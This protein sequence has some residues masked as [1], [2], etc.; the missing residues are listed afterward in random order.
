MKK[1]IGIVIAALI[2][3]GG[4]FTYKN[5]IAKEKNNITTEGNI[6]VNTAISEEKT[7]SESKETVH[8][9]IEQNEIKLEND[10]DEDETKN[11]INTLIEEDNSKETK[12][13]NNKVKK[14]LA[15]SGFMG[16]SLL[17]VTLYDNGEVYLIRY[18][19]EGYEDKNVEN[20]EI[21]ATNAS[22]IKSKGSGEDF[23]A[24]VIKGSSNFKIKNKNYS[25]I[26]FEN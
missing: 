21:L 17:R 6:N 9:N 3:C 5:Y 12:I 18:N 15:P 2:I 20:K 25:W 1:F 7:K 13:I 22:E 26:E 14:T 4:I 19:G 10:N 23:E 24:I 11:A 8:N 16:S